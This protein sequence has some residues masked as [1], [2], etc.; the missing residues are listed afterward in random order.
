MLTV[1]FGVHTDL[2]EL[3]GLGSLKAV[4]CIEVS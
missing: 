3:N 4:L 2:D 1:F